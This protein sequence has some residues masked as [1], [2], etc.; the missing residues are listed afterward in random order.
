MQFHVGRMCARSLW[1][2]HP[3]LHGPE[4]CSMVQPYPCTL[5]RVQDSEALFMMALKNHLEDMEVHTVK[6]LQLRGAWG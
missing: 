5:L 3:R 6:E 4:Q 2:N 1:R